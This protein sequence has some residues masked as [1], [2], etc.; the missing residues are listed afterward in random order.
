MKSKIEKI[1]RTKSHIK[2][3][4]ELLGGGIPESSTVLLFG[5]AGVGKTIFSL[6]FLYNGVKYKNETGI[7]FT[8]EEKRESLINQTKQLG[9]DFEKYEKENKIKIISINE[10]TITKHSIEDMIEIIKKTKVKRCI[11]DSI[12]TLS[13]LS[14]K[15]SNG[16]ITEYQIKKFIYSFISKFNQIKGLTT[17]FISQKDEHITNSVVKYLSDG[18]IEM[19]YE[20]LSGEYSRTIRIKKMRKVKNNEDLHPFEIQNK[21]GIVIHNLD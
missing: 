6:E 18:I 17:I 5:E 7:Y 8:F 19:E 12:T 13:Y 21:K 11:I 16:N 3:F 1:K 10:E 20:S 9:W 14:P 2:G 4:D 15:N